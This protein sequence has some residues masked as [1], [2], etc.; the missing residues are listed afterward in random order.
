MFQALFLQR[1]FSPS[2]YNKSVILNAVTYDVST[3]TTLEKMCQDLRYQD[4]EIDGTVSLPKLY[5]VV[6]FFLRSTT[7][8][9]FGLNF[10]PSQYHSVFSGFLKSCEW[11]IP[12]SSSSLSVK[13]MNLSAY[14]FDHRNDKLLSFMNCDSSQT[15]AIQTHDFSASDSHLFSKLESA[16]PDD[17]FVHTDILVHIILLRYNN[18]DENSSKCY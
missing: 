8:N 9:R 2:R 10:T 15:Y 18:F 1:L 5:N 17:F 6:S 13:S 3:A 14:F 16:L 11:R 7:L 4:L 12:L